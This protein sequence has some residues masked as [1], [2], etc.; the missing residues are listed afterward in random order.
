V[1]HSNDK[2]TERSTKIYQLSNFLHHVVN[3]TYLETIAR[4]QN[5]NREL[6]NIRFEVFMAIKLHT[7]VSVVVIPGCYIIFKGTGWLRF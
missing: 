5:C 2:V 1:Q 6:S 7:V 4:D 3:L